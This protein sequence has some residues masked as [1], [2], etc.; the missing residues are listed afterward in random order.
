[1]VLKNL[2]AGLKMKKRHR[3]QN[4]RNGEREGEGEKYGE[5]YRETYLTI[6]KTGSNW[7]LLNASG[8]SKSGS[9]ST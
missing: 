1:M 2:F 5:S 6:C 3:K 7:N 8:N 9:V 4:K